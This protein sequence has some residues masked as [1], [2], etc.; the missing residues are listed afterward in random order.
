M[1]V[2]D[3]RELW[4]AYESTRFEANVGG[5]PVAV[6]IGETSSSLDAILRQREHAVWVFITAWNPASAALAA[7]DNARRNRDLLKQLK[8]DGYV[9]FA[10][11]GV[12]ADPGWNAEES[13]LALGVSRDAAIQLGRAFGQNAVVWGQL[14]QPAELLDCRPA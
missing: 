5:E 9:V 7:E 4:S 13:Y 11:A 12:P 10:G 6:R 14:G 2:D 3:D 8:G 1:S